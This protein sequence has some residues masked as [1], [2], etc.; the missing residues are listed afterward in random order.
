MTKLLF[1][2]TVEE[3]ATTLQAAKEEGF[4]RVKDKSQ[5]L[6][7][8]EK[9]VIK[10]A[11]VDLFA[12]GWTGQGFRGNVTDWIAQQWLQGTRSAV[13]ITG[14]IRQIIREVAS[15]GPPGEAP[16]PDEAAMEAAQVAAHVDDA[17]FAAEH[18]GDEEE[19]EEEDMSI[20][21]FFAEDY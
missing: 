3:K 15:L 4:I 16:T 18:T 10:E 11:L 17:Q 6:T 19:E 2:H 8:D 7:D 14:H 5:D 13:Q 21:P 12:N 1:L 20:D 9:E